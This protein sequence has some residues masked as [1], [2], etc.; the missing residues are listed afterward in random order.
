MNERNLIDNRIK[1]ARLEMNMTQS[2]LAKKVNHEKSSISCIERGK[3]SVLA[4]RL[5]D[6]SKAL[7]K[8]IIYFLSD[9]I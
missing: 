5:I 9:V 4:E 7:N 6:F 1:Q 2:D 3:R 8:P